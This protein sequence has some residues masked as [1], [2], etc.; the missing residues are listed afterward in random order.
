EDKPILK[1]KI[2]SYKGRGVFATKPI[3]KGS[4]VLEYRGEL[5]TK[6]ES[7]C[8]EG[9]DHFYIL[10]WTTTFFSYCVPFSIDASQEDGSLGRL[11][12]DDHK[13]PNCRMKR[14]MVDK[15]PHLCLFAIEDTAIGTEITYNYGDTKWPC[16]LKHI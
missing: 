2:D 4:F 16:D 13:L 14:I 7:D 8:S 10:V 15:K 12:N 1:E 3:E 5:I 9:F 11:V 6:E